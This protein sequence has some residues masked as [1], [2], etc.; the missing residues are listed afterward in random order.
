MASWNIATFQNNTIKNIRILTFTIMSL[1]GCLQYLS[2]PYTPYEVVAI[3]IIIF[4]NE[5]IEV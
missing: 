1:L 4:T 3:I 2:I 5:E